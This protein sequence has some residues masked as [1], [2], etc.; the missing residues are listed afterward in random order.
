[1]AQVGSRDLEAIK[2]MKTESVANLETKAWVFKVKN[3]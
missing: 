1:M 2:S 3:R